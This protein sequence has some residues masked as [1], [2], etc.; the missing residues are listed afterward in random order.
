[1]LTENN[2]IIQLLNKGII[3]HCPEFYREVKSEQTSNLN[4]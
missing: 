1:M 3:A 2:G 4:M